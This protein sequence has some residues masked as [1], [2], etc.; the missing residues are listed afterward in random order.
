[1]VFREFSR[2][3]ARLVVVLAVSALVSTLLVGAARPAGPEAGLI[4]FTRADG[5]YVMNADGS[6]VRALKRGVMVHGMHWSP[7]GR[8]LAFVAA[9][10]GLWT[11][12]A[13][14]SGLVRLVADGGTSPVKRLYS[15]TWAP[16]GRRIAF[17]AEAAGAAPRTRDIWVVDADGSHLRQLLKTPRLWE[18]HVDWSPAGNRIAFTDAT[19]MIFQ[20]YVMNANGTNRR[21]VTPD[22]RTLQAISPEWSP[23][24]RRLAFTSFRS[25][26]TDVGQ[27]D[28]PPRDIEIWVANATGSLRVR[29]TRNAVTDSGPTW[30]QDGRRIAFVRSTRDAMFFLL[31]EERSPAEIYVMNADGT[32]LTRLTNNE[33][34][35]GTPA[36]QPHTPSPTRRG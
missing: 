3:T 15:A 30:S 31:T 36:W 13:D 19:G 1:M 24:G 22:W 32:G 16:G 9:G 2:R 14:G 11:M 26:F 7:N 6:D 23:D 28:S 12:N 10:S 34:G 8:K 17:T 27:D 25:E 21:V 35:E 20:L 29:L 4:A 18:F 33:L 5:I